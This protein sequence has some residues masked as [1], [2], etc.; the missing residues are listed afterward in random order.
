MG[1]SLSASMRPRVVFPFILMVGTL[2]KIVAGA[3]L[4]ASIVPFAAGLLRSRLRSP[5]LK[6]LWVWLALG[7]VSNFAMAFRT[8]QSNQTSLIAHVGYLILGLLGLFAISEMLP[9][10]KHKY[11][12]YGAMVMYI[13]VWLWRIASGEAGEQFSRVAGP[14][15]WVLLTG[16]SAL[17]IGTRLASPIARPFRDFGVLVDLA[18]MVSYAPSAALE[19]VSYELFA[20]DPVLTRWL[21]VVRGLLLISGYILFTLAFL[22]TTPPRSLSGS[23]SSVAPPPAS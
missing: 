18:V 7:M 1:S 5:E 11:W 10:R 2:I 23:S 13:P 4:I 3:G 12:I 22:W 9:Q 21:Y 19:P 8:L 15:L 14:V 17:L 16:A 6:V 20:S